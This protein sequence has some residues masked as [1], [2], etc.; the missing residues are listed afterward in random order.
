MSDVELSAEQKARAA[1][2]K[3]ADDLRGFTRHLGSFL[4]VALFFFLLN[5]VTDPG[6]WWFFWPLLVWGIGLAIHG[7]NVL[8]NDRW[9]DEQWA[10]RKAQTLLARG[11][12][13]D[14]AGSPSDMPQETGSILRQSAIL[15]DK[16]RTAARQIPKPDV[17]REALKIC[18]SA[19]QVL[20]AVADNPREATIARDF[21]GR[22]LTP[23]SAIISDYARL[24]TRNV[25][26]ARATLAKVEEHDLPLLTTKLDELYDRLHRGN[27]IDLEVAREMLSFDVADWRDGDVATDPVSRSEADST[28][29]RTP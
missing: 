1:A 5:L 9:F 6:N 11:R 4:S 17:R 27:L 15:I 22:Y 25:P 24:S 21:L 7:W 20:S 28:P 16:M 23:A 29:T 26:S 19:D 18:A 8:W 13:A 14:S 10:E 2:R 12:L 3:R